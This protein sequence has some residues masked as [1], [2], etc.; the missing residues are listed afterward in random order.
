MPPPPRAGFPQPKLIESTEA[1]QALCDRLAAEQFVTVDTEFMRERTYWPELCVV[2]LGGS[3]AVY[4]VDAEAD[5]IDLALL[6]DLLANEAVTK[7]F[8]ACRQDIEIFVLR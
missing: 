5:G 8:H 3:D 4:V 6:G 7:V 2:Q 1:L